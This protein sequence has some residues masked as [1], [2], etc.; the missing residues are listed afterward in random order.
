MHRLLRVALAILSIASLAAAA[1]TYAL[2]ETVP[3]TLKTGNHLV[4]S[5]KVP[6]QPNNSTYGKQFFATFSSTSACTVRAITTGPSE[7]TGWPVV[8]SLPGT[9]LV[10]STPAM[11]FFG[12]PLVDPAVWTFN[13]SLINGSCS[14]QFVATEIPTLPLVAG[15][16][17]H[18]N[19]LNPIGGLFFLAIT[20]QATNLFNATFSAPVGAGRCT[21]HAKFSYA[22]RCPNGGGATSTDKYVT[23]TP[24]T[25]GTLSWFGE[26]NNSFFDGVSGFWP[27]HTA[28]YM[29]VQANGSNSAVCSSFKV[30]IN[31]VPPAPLKLGAAPVIVK[32]NPENQYVVGTFLVA[33][34]SVPYRLLATA[35]STA[36]EGTWTAWVGNAILP[37][38]TPCVAIRFGFKTTEWFREKNATRYDA[39][40]I[41][42]AGETW[43]W[44]ALVGSSRCT[45]AVVAAP[46]S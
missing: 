1:K 18:F 42:P 33:S 23:V 22:Y 39:P 7:P 5:V 41:S 37:S 31:D 14:G 45:F 32:S 11:A 34:P 3:I 25:S 8:I 44:A 17:A 38:A 30:S 43:I 9:K 15:Y 24:G 40:V 19:N 12:P 6:A 20:T 4:I 26:D 2:N 28:I 36:C 21:F 29:Y 10:F 16:G 13:L 46:A 35:V 27:N